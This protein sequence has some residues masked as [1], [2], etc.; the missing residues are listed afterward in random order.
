V[1]GKVQRTISYENLIKILNN[2]RKIRKMNLSDNEKI[3][4]VLG[5]SV[6]ELLK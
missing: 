5:V 2:L 3:T 4:K 6:G 1:K